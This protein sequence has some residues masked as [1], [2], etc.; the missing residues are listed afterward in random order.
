MTEGA[1]YRLCLFDIFD[2]SEINCRRQSHDH[3]YFYWMRTLNFG[4][5]GY[6]YY[7]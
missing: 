7:I 3:L 5:G 1:L 6:E 2:A 4:G